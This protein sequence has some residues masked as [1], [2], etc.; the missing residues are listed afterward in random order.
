MT[1]I[2][3]KRIILKR[4]FF[5]SL[6]QIVFYAEWIEWIKVE[7]SHKLCYFTLWIWVV[8]GE[9]SFEFKG[10]SYCWILFLRGHFRFCILEASHYSP[11]SGCLKLGSAKI[12][13]SRDPLQDG[14]RRDCFNWPLCPRESMCFSAPYCFAGLPP[15]ALWS[16]ASFLGPTGNPH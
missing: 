8:K 16:K 15:T 3:C 13:L 10:S 9:S 7:S 6:D 5:F 2:H 4:H 11:E 12:E 1:C 14:V